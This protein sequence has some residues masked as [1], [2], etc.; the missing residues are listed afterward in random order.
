[1]IIRKWAVTARSSLLK[2]NFRLWGCWLS[3]EQGSLR[4]MTQPTPNRNACPHRFTKKKESEM[5]RK[6]LHNLGEKGVWC[7]EGATGSPGRG[8]KRKEQQFW[9]TKE[10]PIEKSPS[11]SNRKLKTKS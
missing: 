11:G 4:Y 8:M 5:V 1:M 2:K 9:P 3:L 10:G 6:Q 7:R